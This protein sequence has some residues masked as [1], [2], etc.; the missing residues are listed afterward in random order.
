MEDK[1][2]RIH[3]KSDKPDNVVEKENAIITACE[4]IEKELPKYLRGYFSYLRGNV[5]PMT[6]LAYLRD[7]RFFLQYLIDESG[8]TEAKEIKDWQVT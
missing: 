3:N 5:L 8:L 6:R 4:D 7:I 2:I 1:K